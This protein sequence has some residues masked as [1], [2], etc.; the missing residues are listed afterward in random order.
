[1][2]LV[3][4]THIMRRHLLRLTQNLGTGDLE[5]VLAELSQRL[6]RFGGKTKRRKA[7]STLLHLK[8][9]VPPNQLQAAV[10]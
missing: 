4:A 6:Q 5:D 10:A 2:S 8:R 7:P 3:K 1:L 9:L